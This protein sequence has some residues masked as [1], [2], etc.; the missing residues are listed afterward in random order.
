M[1][2]SR[3]HFF[4]VSLL[5]SSFLGASELRW[6]W[7][8]I[9][10]DAIRFKPNFIFGTAVAEHQVSGSFESN[11][12]R[13]D[14]AVDKKGKTRIANG[15]KCGV[16][17]DFW[18]RYEQDIELLKELKIKA[19]RFSV[20]WSMIEPVQGQFNQ[21]AI[22]HYHD[23]C[24][25]LIAAGIAPV[26]T[27]HHFVHPVWFEDMGAFEDESN[28]HH[29]VNFCTRMVKEFGNKVALWATFNE[30]G[31]YVFQ[32]YI[33]AKWPPFKHG[34]NRAGLVTLNM[35]KAHV[36]A[37]QAIKALPQGKNIKVGLVHSITHFDPY[38]DN[39]IERQGCNLLNGLFHESITKFFETGNFEWYCPVLSSIEYQNSDAKRALDF[40][41]IN[42]YSHILLR[43]DSQEQGQAYRQDEIRTDM[44]YC[45][46]PEGMYR[47]IVDVS[48]RIARA[49]KIPIYITE[50]GIADAKDE[51]RELFIKR[52]IYAMHK[53][54]EEGHDV[55]GYFYWSLMDNFEWTEGYKMKFGL[56]DVDFAT[57]KRT[58][59][60][61]S[62]SF[63]RIVENTYNPQTIKLPRIFESTANAPAAVA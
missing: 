9:D 47:A 40:F 14:G 54:M 25:K 57:Q 16:A 53:A 43:V 63:L 1:I 31:V 56:Y 60:N 5:F 22:D 33:M 61:G 13:V 10:V 15:D 39:F 58:L 23:L 27:L 2:F 51:N 46:Y 26:V 34:I 6:D 3:S 12:S 52:Y 44:P 21:A 28:N 20:D 36:D 49:Q 8:T 42:Y 4:V 19:F 59:R 7:N 11:W 62:R 30:P 18:N 24:D 35:L 17:C 45:I 37:Y 38:N 41:G 32:G 29:F 55:R 48:K 50:N